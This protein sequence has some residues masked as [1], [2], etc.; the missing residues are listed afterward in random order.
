MN[1]RT[2]NTATHLS[3]IA[4]CFLLM[5]VTGCGKGE[6]ANLVAEANKTKIQRAMNSYL[7]YQSRIHKA[8]PSKEELIEFIKTNP[9]IDKNLAFMGIDRDTFEE[10]LISDRD[11]AEYFF[12]WGTFIKRP[13]TNEPLVFETVGVDGK[14]QVIWSDGE[15]EEYEGKECEDL[16]SGKFRRENQ[17]PDLSPTQSR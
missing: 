16:K 12:R 9:N 5:A 15:V 2:Y 1:K 4:L 10:N 7:L 14:Y 11:G 13:G 17:G 8:A 6:V 3:L